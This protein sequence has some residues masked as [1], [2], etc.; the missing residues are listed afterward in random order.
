MI[1][2]IQPVELFSHPT[3]EERAPKSATIEESNRLGSSNASR[4]RFKHS[5]EAAA[6]A[7]E[8]EPS[9]VSSK[10]F[11]M[12]NH[13]DIAISTDLE[14][15]DVFAFLILFHEAN[16]IYK[17]TGKYP[18]DL[19]IVGEGNT[20]IKKMRMEKLIHDYFDVPPE[21]TIQVVEGRSSRSNIFT[22]DGEELFSRETLAAVPFPEQDQTAHAADV[23][24]AWAEQAQSPMIIQLKPA[25]ELLSLPEDLAKKIDVL[26][27]GSFNLRKTAD[28]PLLLSD[29]ELGF[30]HLSTPAAKLE[31]LM[32]LFSQR[33]NQLGIIETFGV[34]GDQASVA[35]DFPWSHELGNLV[36]TSDDP[37]IQMFRTLCEKWNRYTT[38]R[39][40]ADCLK[41]TKKLPQSPL[42]THLQTEFEALSQ[43]FNQQQFAKVRETIL[44]QSTQ[45][46][47]TLDAAAG[48]SWNTMVRKL[49]LGHKI[50][51]GVQFTLAD[52]LVAMAAT[53]RGSELFHT[54]PIQA[55]YDAN[56]FLVPETDDHSNIAH[57]GRVSP[58]KIANWL[59]QHL[60]ERAARHFACGTPD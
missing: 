7:Y 21:V 60:E 25:L 4:R 18:I 36:A 56:G 19:I 51:Q 24:K 2:E 17:A 9:R 6:I 35:A 8:I 23:L 13:R 20:A 48:R 3:P 1:L 29:Q 22:Y 54:S 58:E 40:L 53:S 37:F 52:I 27:Y 33:F 15:D 43:T 55:K 28:D 49:D 39:I 59:V 10:D 32:Q 38:E 31:W 57:Y 16:E 12:K 26:F 14:P 46:L 45:I 30:A 42:T 11:L 47:A 34:L 5:I 44:S 41:I 50:N